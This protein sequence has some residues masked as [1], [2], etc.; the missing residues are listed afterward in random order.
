MAGSLNEIDALLIGSAPPGASAFESLLLAH[1]ATG[2]AI[3]CA[4]SAQFQF[5]TAVKFFDTDITHFR[6]FML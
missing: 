6:V 2:R 4:N 1:V 3:H 5:E